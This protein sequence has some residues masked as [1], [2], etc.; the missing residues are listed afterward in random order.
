MCLYWLILA[1]IGGYKKTMSTQI[2]II[3]NNDN[4]FVFFWHENDENG[5]LSNN[6]KFPYYSIIGDV[7]SDD[8][9]YIKFSCAEIDF[10]YRKALLFGDYE[11]ARE[12]IHTQNIK[13]AISLGKNIKNFDKDKWDENKK[14]IMFKVLINKFRNYEL[15]RLLCNTGNA[16]IVNTSV[17]DK[18]W[19]IGIR[20]DEKG[21]YDIC[22]GKKNGKNL[23]GEILMK[24]R[25]EYQPF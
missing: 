13:R 16:T 15:Q 2:K 8:N 24:V 7:G 3:S 23:L 10:I 19:G 5:F 14:S 12:L 21:I 1:C 25:K 9:Q 22:N 11:V 20:D 17:Y 18:I 4:D 6:Y